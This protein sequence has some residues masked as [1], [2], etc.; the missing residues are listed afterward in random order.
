MFAH[1]GQAP[2]R[3]YA[4]ALVVLFFMNSTIHSADDARFPFVVD[5]DAKKGQTD[6]LPN[7]IRDKRS[8]M[9]Y[10]LV[11]AGKYRIGDDK[12]ADSKKIEVGVRTFYI[13]EEEVSCGQVASY[14]SETLDLFEK[15]TDEHG[16]KVSADMKLFARFYHF[17]FL[18]R[19]AWP[20]D[21]VLDDDLESLSSSVMAEIQATLPKASPRKKSLR[22]MPTPEVMESLNLE[23]SE[24]QRNT[25]E[26]VLAAGRKSIEELRKRGGKPY[27]TAHH[28]NAVAL[29]EWRG[30]RL[31]TEAEWEVAA[32]LVESGAAPELK[33][34]LQ[35]GVLEW[36]SDYYAHDYFHRTDGFDN[37]QGPDR[38]RLSSE[39]IKS[40]LS[41]GKPKWILSLETRGAGVL[42]GGDVSRRDFAS[43]AQ[44]GFFGADPFRRAKSVRLAFTPRERNK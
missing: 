33:G 41:E 25:M 2:L 20:Y 14:L 37:P 38:G 30:V 4:C 9:W 29:A 27:G 28:M 44:G 7:R 5:I 21:L 3:R 36:C 23:L 35:N 11:P 6:D 34:M 40:E 8:G 18:L 10:I 19:V 31:P 43:R 39:Q 13:A 32:R 17:D 24:K 12:L 22:G 26:R 16:A 1:V 15:Q 42:R